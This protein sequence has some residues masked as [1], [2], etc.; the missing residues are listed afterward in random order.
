MEGLENVNG[1]IAALGFLAMILIIPLIAW[2]VIY[3]IGIWKLLRV[4][5]ALALCSARRLN[6]MRWRR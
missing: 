2:L 1:A 3:I 4:C 5:I 6:R